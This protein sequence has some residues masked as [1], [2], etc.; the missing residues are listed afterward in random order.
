MKKLKE[1]LL[2]ER[3]EGTQR[4]VMNLWEIIFL[5]LVNDKYPVVSMSRWQDFEK[6]SQYLLHIAYTRQKLCVYG[7]ED[8]GKLNDI[9]PNKK[10]M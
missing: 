1:V 7:H 4:L 8:E 5:Q 2:T 9:I 10:W 6:N 3:K